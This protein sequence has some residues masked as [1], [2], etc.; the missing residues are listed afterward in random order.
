MNKRKL[1]KNLGLIIVGVEILV[2]VALLFMALIM[3]AYAEEDCGI[4]ETC[5]CEENWESELCVQN[6]PPNN[7]GELTATAT[8]TPTLRV[9]ETPAPTVTRTPK[10][11][12]TS[13]PYPGKDEDSAGNPSDI[14]LVDFVAKAP[15]PIKAGV[16][17]L[18]ILGGWFFVLFVIR[19]RP[20][21]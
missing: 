6:T 15:R 8:N 4:G 11:T 7:P 17:V 5:Y 19:P 16:I 3:T 9:E 12:N 10:P 2:M 21:K 20:E 18:L 14:G 1:N 13:N